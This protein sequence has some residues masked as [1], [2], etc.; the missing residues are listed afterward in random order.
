MPTTISDF[1]ELLVKLY[2]YSQDIALPNFFD[3]GQILSKQIYKRPPNAP[4][5][6][7]IA[8]TFKI[9]GEFRV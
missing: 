5:Y 3:L 2:W 9:W 4:V 8:N 7:L 1:Y 6:L